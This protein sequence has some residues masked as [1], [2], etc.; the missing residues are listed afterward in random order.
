[1]W[2]FRKNKK[3]EKN[4]ALELSEYESIDQLIKRLENT[5]L[6]SREEAGERH[7]RFV[8]KAIDRMLDEGV[9]R[10]VAADDHEM[11]K[12][13]EEEFKAHLK[14]TDNDLKEQISIFNF[15][16]NR[17]FEYGETH[18]PYFPLRIA[19]ILSKRKELEKEKHFLAAY[20]R[21]FKFRVGTTDQKITNRA[22]KKGAISPDGIP[23]KADV[24]LAANKLVHEHGT[25]ARVISD[26]MRTDAYNS[27]SEVEFLQKDLIWEA[28]MKITY[29]PL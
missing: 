22:I 4:F 7:K 18:P 1:M 28:V 10:G 2:F 11:Y 14:E 3:D 26:G 29:K 17:W 23:K 24:L 5:P 6:L 12:Q 19:I 15:G 25:N 8:K 9:S 20:C 13:S 21:H 16:L 27:G